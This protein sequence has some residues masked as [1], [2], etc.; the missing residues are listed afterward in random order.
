MLEHLA[1]LY[2]LTFLHRLSIKTTDQT[3]LQ[4]T[5]YLEFDRESGS[6][7]SYEASCSG[8]TLIS[9][10]RQRQHSLR[11]NVL[12]SARSLLLVCQLD[13]YQ[14]P[15]RHMSGWSTDSNNS[16]G[17]MSQ[18]QQ[19]DSQQAEVSKDKPTVTDQNFDDWSD[20]TDPSERRKIQ[21]KLAQRG[22]RKC[23]TAKGLGNF[24]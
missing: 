21:N 14:C 19:S 23:C 6:S 1:S 15:L 18:G 20:V 17:Q 8:K 16:G 11:E 12:K 3:S 22:Y 2:L 4:T 7:S 13:P 24:R 10:F 5:E 9:T